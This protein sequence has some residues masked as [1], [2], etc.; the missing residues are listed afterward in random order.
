MD[1]CKLRSSQLVEILPP[2]NPDDDFNAISEG[3]Y[4]IK[5][6]GASRQLTFKLVK[7]HAP[8][9]EVYLEIPLDTYNVACRRAAAA[10]QGGSGDNDGDE[11]VCPYNLNTV[12]LSGCLDPLAAVPGVQL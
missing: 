4:V 9:V 2:Q 7:G 6:K 5:G 12:M 3:L 10:K 1:Q 11:E 8:S